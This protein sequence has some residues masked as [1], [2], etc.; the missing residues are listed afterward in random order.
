[1]KKT[2][3]KQ[4]KAAL[5]KKL[6]TQADA[7]SAEYV[8]KSSEEI[9][10]RLTA[11]PQWQNAKTVFIYV[12]VKNEPDTRRAIESAL[13]NGKRVCVP[14]CHGGGEMSA[15]QITSLGGLSAAPL[16]LLEPDESAPLILPDKIDLIVAPCV[17]AAKN[18]TRLGHG[19]GYYDRYLAKAACP[20]VC[21]CHAK[22]LQ[23]EIP[24]EETDFS[25]AAII[26]GDAVYTL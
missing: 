4:Q 5:R 20:A 26:T 22:L 1:M 13:A 23:A 12:S 19:G 24:H 17:A 16:G 2:A 9:Y 21:L 3:L 11:L 6:L 15:R 14:R 8:K 25:V 7:L 10:A 18:G